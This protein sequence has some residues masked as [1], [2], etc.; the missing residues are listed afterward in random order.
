MKAYGS[1]C[2]D[3]LFLTSALAGGEWSTSRPDRFTPGERASGTLFLLLARNLNFSTPIVEVCFYLFLDSTF[4][5]PFPSGFYHLLLSYFLAT[6]QFF[7][8]SPKFSPKRERKKKG[9]KSFLNVFHYIVNYERQLCTL[10]V[11]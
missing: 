10:V 11:H 9:G 5:F 8:L 4:T 1:E 2:I 6:L 7:Y 3:P